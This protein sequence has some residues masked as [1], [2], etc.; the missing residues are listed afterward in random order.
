MKV[1]NA[2]GLPRINGTFSELGKLKALILS[3]PGDPKIINQSRDFIEVSI[4]IY[5][6]LLKI[7]GLD[8]E[9]DLDFSVV[10]HSIQ[11]Q[12]K[13]H[14]LARLEVYRKLANSEC[15]TNS[16]HWDRLLDPHQ[17]LAAS[18]M[19]TDGLLGMCIFDEQGT[20][21]TITALASFDL[22]RSKGEVDSLVVVAPKTLVE[23]WRDESVQ[24]LSQWTPQ[25]FVSF[26]DRSERF[27]KIDSS[28][29]IYLL[30]Y[31]NLISDLESYKSL[32]KTKR[33]MLIADESFYV[34]NPEAIRSIAIM[35]FRKLCNK[36][37][38]LC[39][40]PAPNRPTDLIHQFT[41]S[42]NG[43][44][45]GQSDAQAYSD[46]DNFQ[47]IESIIESRG[48][49]LRRTKKA[50][51]PELPE[52]NYNVVELDLEPK[53]QSLY[54]EAKKELVLYLKSLDNKS[55][56]RN[57]ATYFQKRN[58]LLQ[59]C[60]D[61]ALIDP[62]YNEIPCKFKYL[63]NF[64][65]DIILLKNKK[66]VI[67]SVYTKTIDRLVKNYAHYSPAR[68]DG[69]IVKVSDRKLMV[70]RF[71]NDDQCKIFVGNPAAA[72]AGITLHKAST[73]IYLSYS[74]QAAHYMQSIDRI[75]RRGQIANEVN[76]FFLVGKNTIESKEVKRLIE[77]Q[78]RQN[79]LLGDSEE[80]I[81]E[82]SK[83]I[84]ELEND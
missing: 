20:G 4:N 79:S 82:L 63:T 6:E 29:D 52:K 39:G 72:G 78:E 83:I 76:Y 7:Q 60:I 84:A 12:Y 13:K 74:N 28:Y 21:K 27:R 81:I 42:D 62:L 2:N 71:Q 17:G 36:C 44:S 14:E 3:L 26:G 57:L 9:E 15:L 10:S 59:I 68:I 5:I 38:V 24:F 65:E 61:P 66:V 80:E 46:L 22:L 8:F 23:N 47:K 55:F 33:L 16:D 40:T 51:L 49:Y 19:S 69:Q 70:D 34:K 32:A 41:L 77:K 54:D 30:T 48:V 50:V 45:F 11:N 64:L 25:I 73:A 35:S 56:K 67:W 53:Q 58:A 1:F 75:H 43:Y 31:E 18:C 37:F